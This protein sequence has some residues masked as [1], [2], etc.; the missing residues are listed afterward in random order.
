MFRHNSQ[1]LERFQPALLPQAT[2]VA[3]PNQPAP[4]LNPV[5]RRNL[6][7]TTLLSTEATNLSDGDMVAIMDCF[8]DDV[9]Y[10]DAYLVLAGPQANIS[11]RH[12]WLKKRLEEVAEGKVAKQK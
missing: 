11:I 12:L 2:A 3:S 1:L 9:S 7:T 8:H 5:M 4:P 6:A 10:A